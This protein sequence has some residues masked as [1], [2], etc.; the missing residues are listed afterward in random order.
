MASRKSPSM[1][2]REAEQLKRDCREIEIAEARR[3]G[4]AALIELQRA[5]AA[6]QA[7]KNAGE[8][9]DLHLFAM[10]AALRNH[11]SA[12]AYAAEQQE[13]LAKKAGDE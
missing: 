1:S 10:S 3:R 2:F 13:K 5:H 6:Y 8:R 4:N 11:D 9:G 7:A 12:H